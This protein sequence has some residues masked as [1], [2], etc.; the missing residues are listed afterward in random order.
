MHVLGD[1]DWHVAC[2]SDEGHED[3]IL[4]L[5]ARHE[6]GLYLVAGFVHCVDD[7]VG[8]ERDEFHSGVVVDR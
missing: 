7:L 1:E 5:G 3:V 6:D 4:A 2:R 8:L